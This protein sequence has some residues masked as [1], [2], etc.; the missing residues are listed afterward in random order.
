MN[1]DYKKLKQKPDNWQPEYT[2][3]RYFREPG[4]K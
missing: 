4:E 1:Y 3:D 2:L